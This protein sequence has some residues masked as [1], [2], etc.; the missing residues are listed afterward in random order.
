MPLSVFFRA[1]GFAAKAFLG[2]SNWIESQSTDGNT[3]GVSTRMRERR[4]INNGG[5][6]LGGD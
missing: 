2:I 4:H 6:L 3:K 5:W 1:G